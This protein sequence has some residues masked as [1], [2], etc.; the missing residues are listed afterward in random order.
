[1][2]IAVFLW[3]DLPGGEVRDLP[4]RLGDVRELPGEAA[5]RRSFPT[6]GEMQLQMCNHGVE[7]AM[8]QTPTHSN[9]MKRKIP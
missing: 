8:A 5:R 6:D 1:M 3:Y 4:A 7:H 9:A 2:H